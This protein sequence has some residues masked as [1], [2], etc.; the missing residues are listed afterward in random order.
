ML[1]RFPHRQIAKVIGMFDRSERVRLG[2]LF[3]AMLVMGLMDVI[4]IS[5]ILPFLAVLAKPDAIHTLTPLARTYQWLGFS[6]AHRFLFFLGLLALVAIL[7]S[8][9]V[10]LLVNWGILRFSHALGHSL[11][12][13]L[14]ARYL[15][16]PYTF[17]LDR[18]S[19][20][21]M[22]NATGE[23]EGVINGVVLPAMQ[24]LSKLV[25]A[26]GLV[27]L[28]FVVDLLLAS[29]FL[30]IAV[31]AYLLLLLLMQG[32]VTRLGEKSQ[33]ARHTRFRQATEALSSIKDLKVLGREALYYERFRDASSR[34]AHYNSVHGAITLVPRH[35]L[36]A[37]AFGGLLVIVLYLLARDAE[38]AQALPLMALYALTGYRLMPT[39]QQVYQG[40]T[41][42]RFNW[43]SVELVDAELA[44]TAATSVV[45][46]QLKPQAALPMLAGIELRDARFA[47]PGS[48]S[49]AVKGINL[50]IDRNTSIGLVGPT[51]SGKT[52]L[53]DI[54][55]GLLQPDAGL[56]LVDG[57]AINDTNRRAWQANLGYVP[58]Q[59]YLSDDTVARNIAFGL[60]ESEIDLGR[61]EAAARIAHI[62]EFIVDELPR[63]Y[64]TLV[65]ER[66]IRL[67]GGQRQ[68]I[69]IARAVYHSPAV[70]V[71]DEATSALDGI[72]E[73]A[74]I[75]AIQDLSHE[76]TIIT[77]AHR[78]STV[79]DCDR[80]YLLEQGRIVDAG[81]YAE[82]VTRN[83]TFR[84]MAKVNG[85]AI[86][87]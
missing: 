9:A 24:A 43:P 78:L 30:L 85:E 11:S 38:L 40:M 75:D 68:R 73:D 83:E 60:P 82:L 21:L 42:I 37:V 20:K 14:L 17:F 19:T 15:C 74:I 71:F 34:Y 44:A 45:I 7:V 55:L 62:H 64:S 5:S 57:I 84:A 35:V 70:L 52:T 3:I 33:I 27:L 28:V 8:N 80:I 65:G 76:K 6:D 56:L 59:I 4:G 29:L 1:P 2:W 54:L 49:E 16:Q 81:T 41:M 66:G 10:T 26:G 23:V 12:M 25:V 22:L 79:R 63:S 61:V 67:S 47:Y 53:V 50:S 72:T 77:I 32:R 39:F 86:G 58:Q 36:E 48:E 31:G 87:G 51:G 18:N 46:D 69:G 13:R